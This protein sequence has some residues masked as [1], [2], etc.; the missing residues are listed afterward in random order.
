MSGGHGG[1]G[2][3]K[4][5]IAIVAV[6]V[7]IVLVVVALTAFP[8]PSLTRKQVNGNQASSTSSFNFGFGLPINPPSV[9][10]N[11]TNNPP[12]PDSSGSSSDEGQRGSSGYAAGSQGTGQAESGVQN[13]TGS[14]GS[15]SESSPLTNYT[16]VEVP[17]GFTRS[18]L[19]PYYGK[20]TLNS[21][22]SER[23]ETIGQAVIS[24]SLGDNE[25][26]DVTAWQVKSSRGGSYFIPQ[27]VERY[28]PS[29]VAS[30]TDIVMR[31][32]D[33]LTIYLGGGKS[34]VGVNV[35]LN[36]CF[37]YLPN[38]ADFDPPL[39][40]SCPSIDPS[41][42]SQFTGRCRDYIA[43][44]GSCGI[45]DFS[46]VNMPQNDDACRTFLQTLNYSGC[47]ARHFGDKDFLL[48]DIRVWGS[49]GFLDPRHDK[50]LLLDTRGLLVSIYEY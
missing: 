9:G 48:N 42:Y 6:M 50:V 41:E 10:R 44:L 23:F 25:R 27:A 38:L 12:S 16:G 13:D 47:F 21:V 32:N 11:N 39:Y 4:T 18:Q 15:G 30:P 2:G 43:S 29:G 3:G 14:A 40:A 37:G 8:L 20:I 19:S 31:G 34:G 17:P 26:V 46:D 24:A 49:G 35:R 45:P 36:E 5:I 33:T 7:F 28:T 22:Y 1:G